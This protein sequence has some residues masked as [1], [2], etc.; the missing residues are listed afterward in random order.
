MAPCYGEALQV[1]NVRRNGWIDV[2]DSA[3]DAWTVNPSRML[4]FMPVEDQK[5]IRVSNDRSE[6]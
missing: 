5:N 1:I 6:P 2:K 3:G 4:G